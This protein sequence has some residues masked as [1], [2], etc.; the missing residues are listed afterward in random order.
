MSRAHHNDEAAQDLLCV[1]SLH[2]HS[3][4]PTFFAGRPVTVT[5]KATRLT[6]ASRI[7]VSFVKSDSI[8]AELPSTSACD[9]AILVRGGLPENPRAEYTAGDRV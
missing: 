1:R 8:A 2:L 4:R 3:A 7:Q 6:L 9:W 5:S